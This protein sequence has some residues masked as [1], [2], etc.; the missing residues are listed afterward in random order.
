MAL[1]LLICTLFA[2]FLSF[3]LIPYITKNAIRFALLD[4]PNKRKLHRAPTP[5]L[6]GVA[7]FLSFIATYFFSPIIESSFKFQ[8]LALVASLI[9]AVGVYDD[10]FN[11]KAAKKAF[12]QLVLI[13]VLYVGGFRLE[14]LADIPYFE[15]FPPVISYLATVLF[16]MT[17][18]NAYNLIDGIDGLAGSLG[19]HACLAFAWLFY[20]LDNV[21]WSMLALSVSAGLV[22]FLKYNFRNASIFMGDNGSMFLGL[23]IAVFSLEYLQCCGTQTAGTSNLLIVLAIIILSLIHI[24]E[25]TRPY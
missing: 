24:S 14:G 12:W 1:N 10:L 25:P 15:Q 2:F 4:Q 19:L 16:V 13:S 23:M 3:L 11:L 5:S 21:S 22:G 6:G 7:I 8:I 9:I 18:I 20:A 17:L